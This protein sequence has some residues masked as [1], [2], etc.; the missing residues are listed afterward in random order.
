MSHKLICPRT[1]ESCRI[2]WFG[3]QETHPITRSPKLDYLFNDVNI[4]RVDQLTY[5]E[6][7][8]HVECEESVRGPTLS[9]SCQ[10]APSVHKDETIWTE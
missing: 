4:V 7:C 10:Y 9:L 1:E 8:S 3:L 5:A 2:I 6:C